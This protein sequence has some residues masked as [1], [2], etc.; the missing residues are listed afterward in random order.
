[1]RVFKIL[2]TVLSIFMLGSC[3]VTRIANLS[4][5]DAHKTVFL[6]GELEYLG[7]SKISVEYRQYLGCIRVIDVVNGEVYNPEVRSNLKLENAPL[8]LWK[9]AP[10]LAQEYPEADYFWVVGTTRNMNLD[11]LLLGSRKSISAKVRAYKIRPPY[12]EE[13]TRQH[14]KATLIK[15]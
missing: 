15:E 4:Y 8:I 7:E 2:L 13:P 12:T 10:H 9:A 11:G 6:D 3:S 1:M 5:N 14:I